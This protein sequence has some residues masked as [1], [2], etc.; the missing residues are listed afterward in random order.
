MAMIHRMLLFTTLC[1]FF[2][3]GASEAKRGPAPEVKPLKYLSYEI[4]APNTPEEMGKVMLRSPKTDHLVKVYEIKVTPSLEKDV[5]WVFIKNMRLEGDRLVV[6]D[7][8]GKEHELD[9][10][11]HLAKCRG[12]LK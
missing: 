6:T 12:C 8:K 10:K 1:L 7:E 2:L 3:T 11:A 4:S 5:Q 9:L